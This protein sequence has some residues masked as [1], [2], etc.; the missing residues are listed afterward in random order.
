M[1]NSRKTDHLDKISNYLLI[2]RKNNVTQILSRHRHS[3][4]ESLMRNK[5]LTNFNPIPTDWKFRGNI[6]IHLGELGLPS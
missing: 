1:Y 5:N 3:K 6:C 2:Y 4:G